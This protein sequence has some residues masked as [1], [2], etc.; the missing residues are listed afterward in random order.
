[1]N[2]EIAEPTPHAAIRTLPASNGQESLWLTAEADGTTGPYAVP[3]G[4]HVAARLTA[5]Q[6]REAAGAA[7]RASRRTAH[8]PALDG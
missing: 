8:R 1:M 7:D 2:T 6:L 3:F 5:A 4:Y